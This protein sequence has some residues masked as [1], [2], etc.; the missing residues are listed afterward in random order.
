MCIKVVE[1]GAPFQQ[2]NAKTESSTVGV[3]R[4]SEQYLPFLQS[5]RVPRWPWRLFAK[6]RRG[7]RPIEFSQ[8]F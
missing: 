6:L 5:K 4:R 7:R 8:V 2:P 3:G 1:P